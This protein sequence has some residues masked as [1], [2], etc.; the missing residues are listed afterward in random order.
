MKLFGRL[1]AILA[2]IASGVSLVF[3]NKLEVMKKYHLSEIARL[4]TSVNVT[5]NKLVSTEKTLAITQ[6][7]LKETQAKL[8]ETTSTL[9]QTKVELATRTEE[10]STATKQVAELNDSLGKKTAELDTANGQ[11]AAI[12]KQLEK[13]GGV[14]KIEEVVAKVTAMFEENKLLSEQLT[15]M[16]GE[17]EVMAAKIVELSTTPIGLRGTVAVAQDSW[18]F[19][20]LDVG[21]DHR[22]QPKSQFLIYRDT[23]L[24]AKAEVIAVGPT[25]SVAEILPDYR[26]SSPRAGDLIVH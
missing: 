4:D 11:L 13:F 23:K 14:A 21:H 25:T 18:N 2:I 3:V 16:R 20:V 1:A 7:N 9:E 12:Q 22:V 6:T 10:L 17:N 26:R 24:V 8:D 5:S 19:V 15:K